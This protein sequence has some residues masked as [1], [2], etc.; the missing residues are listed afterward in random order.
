MAAAYMASEAATEGMKGAPAAPKSNSII[1]GQKKQLAVYSAQFGQF[2]MPHKSRERTLV[3]NGVLPGRR[4]LLFCC[5]IGSGFLL[6]FFT[7]MGNCRRSRL[8]RLILA[9]FELS[10]GQPPGYI[11]HVRTETIPCYRYI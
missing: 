11:I 9:P 7:I 10:M 8:P 5:R 6:H 2:G 4:I 1:C 3:R